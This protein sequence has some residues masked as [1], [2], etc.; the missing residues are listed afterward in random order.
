MEKEEKIRVSQKR[1]KTKTI[2]AWSLIFV[3]VAL[4]ISGI[5][6]LVSKSAD[7]NGGGVSLPA[8]LIFA[9][10]DWL[11]GGEKAELTLIEYSDFQCPACANFH[12]IINKLADDF[13][14]D[15]KIIYRHFPLPQHK[16]AVLAAKAGEAAGKQR[17]FWEMSGLIFNNQD[18]WSEESGQNARDIFKKFASELNLDIAQFENDLESEEIKKSIDDDYKNGVKLGINAT[19]TFFLNGK[20]ITNP[21]SYEEFKEIV[22][23]ELVKY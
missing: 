14:N 4:G 23:E 22:S 12:P 6:F 11:K 19:P 13:N 20:K 3:F 10:D 18:E 2:I 5:I 15:L 16:N 17:K 8:S 1:K 21:R 9:E 7:L